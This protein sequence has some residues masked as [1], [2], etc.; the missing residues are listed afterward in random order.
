MQKNILNTAAL[1]SKITE[2][3]KFTPIICQETRQR[4]ILQAIHSLASSVVN[5][6]E[7]SGCDAEYFSGY[8][9]SIR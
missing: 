1:N 4:I 5:S 9:V 8:F 7:K 2:Q 6:L 3:K